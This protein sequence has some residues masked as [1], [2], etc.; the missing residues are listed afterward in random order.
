MCTIMFLLCSSVPLYF[1]GIPYA[2]S[3]SWD[4]IFMNLETFMKIKLWISDVLY[5]FPDAILTTLWK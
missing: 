1:A 2:L 3:Y 4:E 5:V